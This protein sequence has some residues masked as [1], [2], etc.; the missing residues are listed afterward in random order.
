MAGLLI[1]SIQKDLQVFGPT[2]EAA[3]IEGSKAFAKYMMS[4]YNIPTAAYG[5]FT[6]L[7][8]ALVFRNSIYANC[9]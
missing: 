4:K 8:P 1:N 9:Y 3:L 2:K 7:E 6:E 5:E